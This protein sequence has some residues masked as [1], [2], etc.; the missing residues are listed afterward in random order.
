MM[1]RVTAPDDWLRALERADVRESP[2]SDQVVLLGYP[3]ALGRLQYEWTSDLLREFQLILHGAEQHGEVPP[4]LRRLLTFADEITTK[5]GV[6]MA[7]PEAELDRA[8]AAGEECTV[9][10]YPLFPVSRGILLD[11]ARTMEEADAYCR[12]AALITLAPS[13]E[14]YALRRWIVEEFI[15]QYDGAPPRSWRDVTAA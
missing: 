8:F 9:L 15:R 14:L 13:P 2:A 12:E 1:P 4:V 3:V 10:R 5:Y 7:E 6:Q 11:F